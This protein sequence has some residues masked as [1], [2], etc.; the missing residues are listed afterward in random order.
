M[1]PYNTALQSMKKESSC[2]IKMSGPAPP[3]GADP[4][5]DLPPT[6]MDGQ[7]VAI[8]LEAHLVKEG[9]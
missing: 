1:A 7:M 2:Q 3:E 4:G 8:L 9:I 6:V 5:K